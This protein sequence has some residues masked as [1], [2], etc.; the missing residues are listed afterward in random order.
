VADPVTYRKRHQQQ[1]RRLAHTMLPTEVGEF[2]AYGL[3]DEI[4]ASEH[5]ALVHGDI[6]GGRDVLTRLHSECLTGDVLGS[7]RCDCGPQLQA[8]MARITEE[9]AG[10]VVYLRGHEG[11]G[12]GL[13]A[14]L[15]AYA[16]QDAGRDTVDANLDLGYAAD[17]RDYSAGAQMLRDLGIVS[18]RLLS[19]NP[20]KERALETYGVS[21][22][23]RLALAVEPTAGNLRY[24]QTKA[25]R[26]GHDLPDLA[27]PVDAGATT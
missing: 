20:A 22:S 7:Q 6:G 3:R 9:G 5:V 10:V 24:L 18:V 13:L 25:A 12:I 1:L 16:L 8:S 15:Q 11:R 27:D 23:E 19:N 21:V 2:T 17:S 14:K 4:D 26:M